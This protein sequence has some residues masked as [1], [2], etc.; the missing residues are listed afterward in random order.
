MKRLQVHLNSGGK[1]DYQ[2]TFSFRDVEENEI[3]GVLNTFFANSRK[4]AIV[5]AY[6][7][8]KVIKV[9]AELDDDNNMTYVA[10]L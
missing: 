1:K 10:T 5:K 3:N 7:S 2:N 9:R 6:Y 8:G 4:N